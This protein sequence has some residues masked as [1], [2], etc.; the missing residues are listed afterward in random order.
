[1]SWI[2]DFTRVRRRRSWSRENARLHSKLA[3][4]TPV[5]GDKE[6]QLKTTRLGRWALRLAASGRAYVRVDGGSNGSSRASPGVTASHSVKSSARRR[7][8]FAKSSSELGSGSGSPF[9]SAEVAS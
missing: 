7:R 1:M 3:N 6:L 9:S 5:R 2:F 8:I 4:T